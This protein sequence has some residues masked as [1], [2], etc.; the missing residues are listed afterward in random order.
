MRLNQR[1]QKKR[2][3]ERRIKKEEGV[4]EE[5]KKRKGKGPT[6]NEGK[7]RERSGRVGGGQRKK[8]NREGDSFRGLEERGY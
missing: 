5:R 3:E 7:K 2:G 4:R 1:V 6:E 8:R